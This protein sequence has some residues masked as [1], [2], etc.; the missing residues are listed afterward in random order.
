MA[1]I[2]ELLFTLAGFRREREILTERRAELQRRHDEQAT[3]LGALL[4][5]YALE[6]RDVD[7]LEGLSLT[8]VWAALRGARYRQDALARE[9]AEA[10]A[11]RY[12]AAEAQ[13][14]L[15]A[16]GRELAAADTRLAQLAEVP[17]RYA[18]AIDEKERYVR[19]AGGASA[20]RL[21]A[22]A[23]ERGRTEAELRE[24]G[25]AQQAAENARQALTAVQHN[26]NSA[27]DWSAYDTFLGGGILAS[28]FKH[29]RLDNAARAAAYADRCLAVLRTEL[30]DVGIVAPV[31]R[32]GVRGTTRFVD[33]WFDNIFT[34][35][36]VRDHIKKAR[37]NVAESLR[38]LTAVHQDVAARTATAH[39]RL[40]ELGR[41]RHDLLKP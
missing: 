23:E 32:V 6:Q 4:R 19:A 12:R 26:L 20:A 36:A 33:V 29:H 30:A 39:A 31:G 9:R 18:A 3:D 17:A 13:D 27:A 5:R 35:M 37:R 24:L 21:L 10:D 25:E 38:M 22:L 14:R 40:A 15:D 28:S 34:D 41:A 11:A 16:I 8:R 1:D 7:R 2:E